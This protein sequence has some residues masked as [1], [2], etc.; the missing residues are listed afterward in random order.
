MFDAEKSH[1][2]FLISRVEKIKVEYKGQP[3]DAVM[4]MNKGLST[5][6]NCAMR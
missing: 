1:Q 4:I 6:Y 2:M 3:E 5:P